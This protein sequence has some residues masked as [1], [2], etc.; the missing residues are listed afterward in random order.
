MP[1]PILSTPTFTEVIEFC[2]PP[3]DV[4]PRIHFMITGTLLY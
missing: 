3:I 4:N 2:V 1:S